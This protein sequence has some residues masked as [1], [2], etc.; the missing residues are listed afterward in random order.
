MDWYYYYK[1]SKGKTEIKCANNELNENTPTSTSQERLV[2]V[3]LSHLTP[4]MTHFHLPQLSKL[5]HLCLSS[6]KQFPSHFFNP[7]QIPYALITF[8]KPL[9]SSVQPSLPWTSHT[10][11]FI[12]LGLLFKTLPTNK[13]NISK[14]RVT[15]QC[16]ML[17]Q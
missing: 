17:Q 12:L 6:R 1:V 7:L 14:S 11:S 4:Q 10:L 15:G 16:L 5:A 13:Y 2:W 8:S 9:D 3:S